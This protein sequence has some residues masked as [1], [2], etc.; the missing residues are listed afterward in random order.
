MFNPQKKPVSRPSKPLKG[1]TFQQMQPNR[2]DQD[3]DKKNQQYKEVSQR[4]QLQRTQLNSLKNTL[5]T[6]T[7]QL[8][9]Q[10]QQFN[11]LTKLQNTIV[12]LIQHL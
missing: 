11:I 5:N 7:I 9:N 4:L 10:Q 3:S 6:I 1:S 12:N 8:Q 2:I